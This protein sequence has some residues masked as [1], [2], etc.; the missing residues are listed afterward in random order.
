[1]KKFIAI[2]SVFMLLLSLISVMA[3]TP[4]ASSGI[5]INIDPVDALPLIWMDP[6][7]RIVLRNPADGS[8]E[9]VERVNN[10]AFEGEQIIWNVLVYDGNGIE[11]ISDVYVSIGDVQGS[12]DDIEANCDLDISYGDGDDITQFNAFVGQQ[13]LTVLDSDVM[14]VYNCILTI[15]PDMFDEY[16]V[17][18]NVVDLDGNQDNF[19]E[20]EFWF[21]NPLIQ[22]NINGNV[23]FEDVMPGQLSYSDT[24]TIENAASVGSGVLLDMQISGT[25]FYDPSSSGAKCPVTNRLRL[26]DGGTAPVYDNEGTTNPASAYTRG[27]QSICDSK[28]TAIEK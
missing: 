24:I 19:D 5:G 13:Q 3:D 22:L 21:F 27:E 26:N 28:S 20:N 11:K 23:D 12:G 1:M 9:L 25:D 2:T 17:V 6:S 14:A 18:A 16:W 8:G 4:G 10:Y 15:E 7:S